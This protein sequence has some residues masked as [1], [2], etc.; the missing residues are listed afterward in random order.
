MQKVWH[1]KLDGWWYATFT[2]V[3]HQKQIKLINLLTTF[4][5]Q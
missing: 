4:L 2:E 5:G 1:C 3:G